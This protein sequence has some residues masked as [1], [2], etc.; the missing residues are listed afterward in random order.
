M[1]LVT[2]APAPTKAYLPMVWPR[3]TVALAP[4]EQPFRAFFCIHAYG[5][6]GLRV[7]YI[8][9][10]IEGPQN[11]LLFRPSKSKRCLHFNIVADNNIQI[12]RFAQTAVPNLGV[13]HYMTNAKFYCYRPSR[14]LNLYKMIHEQNIYF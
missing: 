6:H 8:C 1:S 10:T 5:S 12:Q 14:R 3:T 7:D 13:A 4:M 11:A 2:T 9:K